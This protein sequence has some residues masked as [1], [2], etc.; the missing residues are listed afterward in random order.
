MKWLINH[1]TLTA[2]MI[3]MV[4]AIYCADPSESQKTE[5]LLKKMPAGTVVVDT[6]IDTLNITMGNNLQ[7]PSLLLFVSSG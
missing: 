5:P 3:I 7:K 2:V 1:L 6:K 4:S